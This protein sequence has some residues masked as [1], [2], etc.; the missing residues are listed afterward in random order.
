[1]SRLLAGDGAE[2]ATFA[3]EKRIVLDPSQIPDAFRQALI[4]SEDVRFLTH[5][6]IDARGVLRAL[7]TDLRLGRVEEGASTLTMQ[8]AGMLFLDRSQ[9]TIVRKLQEACLALNIERRYSKEEI[10]GLYTNQVHMGHGLFGL[11]A[12]ARHYFGKPARELTLSESRDAGGD[13]AAS[14]KLLSLP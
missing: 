4:A 13:S 8:L 12:A 5:P 2:I 11:G 10:F 3:T 6:G 1:M 9:R 7:R 14:G